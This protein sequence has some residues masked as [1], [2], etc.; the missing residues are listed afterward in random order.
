MQTTKEHLLHRNTLSHQ[1]TWIF[2]SSV[3]E[4]PKADKNSFIKKLR[5]N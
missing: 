3:L 4:L 1:L 5:K 2:S